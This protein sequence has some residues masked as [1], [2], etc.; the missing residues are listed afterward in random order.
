MYFPTKYCVIHSA[1]RNRFEISL[2]EKI[3][4]DP[5]RAEY[6]QTQHVDQHQRQSVRCRQARAQPTAHAGPFPKTI[7]AV[8][9]TVGRMTPCRDR[10]AAVGLQ[11]GHSGMFYGDH[12]HV[13]TLEAEDDTPNRYKV[14]KRA[15]VL[16]LF[17]LPST[18]EL[19]SLNKLIDSLHNHTADS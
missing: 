6:L 2:E 8:G 18:E 3:A 10:M 13:W 4:L 11:A 15:D 19:K 9:A 14:S 17:Y 12:H 5:S 7:D 1:G 16:I